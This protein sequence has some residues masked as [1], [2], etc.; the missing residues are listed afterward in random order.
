MMRRTSFTSLRLIYS[1]RRL[2]T[3][4]TLR[5]T[6]RRLEKAEMRRQL[7]EQEMRHQLL[8]IKE[9]KERQEQIQHRMQEL[10]P[11]QPISPVSLPERMELPEQRVQELLPLELSP[12]V[13]AF[14]EQ[15]PKDSTPPQ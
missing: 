7:L 9:L 13:R 14:L 10:S 12:T 8:L 6:L 15:L 5:T 4:S 1:L 2:S 3:R 11:M